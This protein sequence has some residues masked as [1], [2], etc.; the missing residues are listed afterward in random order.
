M[1]TALER[2]EELK[3]LSEETFFADPHKLS[4]AKYNFIVA[5]EGALDLCNHVI[6]KNGLRTP[7]D[8]ADTFRVLAERGAFDA[9]FTNTL[10]Q[11]ARFRNRLVHIYWE[12]DNRELRSLVHTRLQDIRRFLTVFGA[13]IAS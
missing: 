6:A 9:D 5:I 13:F 1:L 7:E 12:V 10:I 4:S 8:Y 2:L 11:M 3:A